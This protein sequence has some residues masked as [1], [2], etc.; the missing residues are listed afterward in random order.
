[1]SWIASFLAFLTG[2]ALHVSTTPAAGGSFAQRGD[3]NYHQNSRHPAEQFLDRILRTSACTSDRFPPPDRARPATCYYRIDSSH[4]ERGQPAHGQQAHYLVS[5]T[6]IR[7]SQE[8]LNPHSFSRD[9]SGSRR[10]SVPDTIAALRRDSWQWKNMR[11]FAVSS[12]VALDSLPKAVQDIPFIEVAVYKR[13]NVN[14]DPSRL[15]DSLEL[16]K[17]SREDSVRDLCPHPCPHVC[18]HLC[19]QGTFSRWE[20]LLVTHDNRRLYT[21]QVAE[22]PLIPIV[23]V[24]REIAPE[25]LR[26]QQADGWMIHLRRRG[27]H[28][29]RDEGLPYWNPDAPAWEELP[30][31][32]HDAVR[33]DVRD[34]HM[35]DQAAWPRPGTSWE[36][37]V[38]ANHHWRSMSD[39]SS[40]QLM[41]QQNHICGMHQLMLQQNHMQNI[42]QNQ[43]LMQESMCRDILMRN[44]SSTWTKYLD[45][46]LMRNNSST[47]QTRTRE[48]RT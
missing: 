39:W 24:E 7:F 10:R 21:Y 28:G 25:K 8:S 41:L 11:M 22:Q 3:S 23:L 42:M 40:Y 30:V 44:N 34:D 48:I 31:G 2:L 43:I 15:R 32:T 26:L 13:P 5:P 33:D 37:L 12:A 36:V 1:M 27:G 47:R 18:P 6:A 14:N 35:A 4:Q 17:W 29:S 19:P 9:L 16:V 45:D 46:I 20:Y 38:S